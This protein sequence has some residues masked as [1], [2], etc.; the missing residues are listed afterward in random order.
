MIENIPGTANYLDDIIV[1]GKTEKEHLANLEATLAKLQECGFRLG[2]DKF[3][4]F[5]SEIEY[6]SHVI[7]KGVHP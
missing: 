5:K 1:T 4:F 2:M 3:D 7:D 6:L